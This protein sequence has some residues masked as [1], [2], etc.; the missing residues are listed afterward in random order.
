MEKTREE[1][2]AAEEEEMERKRVW[3]EDNEEAAS[4]S[5]DEEGS[6]AATSPTN[7]ENGISIQFRAS[8]KERRRSLEMQLDVQEKVG[9]LSSPNF[10]QPTL[11]FPTPTYEPAR[12][13]RR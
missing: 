7:G 13:A 10:S 11:A 4:S 9:A 6:P 2:V 5:R 1:Q 8:A 12:T 3:D